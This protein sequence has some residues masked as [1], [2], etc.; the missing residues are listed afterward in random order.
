MFFR[1]TFCT[2]SCFIH[3]VFVKFYGDKRN[4]THWNSAF[5]IGQVKA[6]R[7][8]LL[9]GIK[10]QFFLKENEGKGLPTYL[11]TYAYRGQL[12]KGKQGQ[13]F[14]K[15]NEGKSYVD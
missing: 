15:G 4:S 5:S 9:K 6:Y 3:K 7:G 10:D 1:A 11:P 13:F 14:L 8:Q 2:F 12:L